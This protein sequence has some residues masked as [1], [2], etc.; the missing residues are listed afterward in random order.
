MD[1]IF[2]CDSEEDDEPLVPKN[3]KISKNIGRDTITS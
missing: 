3:A 2:G 1:N